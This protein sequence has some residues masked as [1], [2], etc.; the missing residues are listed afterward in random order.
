[1]IVP[2]DDCV[3]IEMDSVKE[4][5]AGGII[6]PDANREMEQAAKIYA[7]L[8]AIGDKAFDGIE[9]PPKVGD[10]IVTTKYPG[11][12]V[13]GHENMRICR[14]IDVLGIIKGDEND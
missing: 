4:K 13:P 11:N 2:I 14:D 12:W 5:T 6:L 1:M 10:R 9:N 3:L 8:R 7:T